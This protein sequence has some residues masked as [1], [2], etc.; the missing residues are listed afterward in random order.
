MVCI[1]KG[2]NNPVNDQ[3]SCFCFTNETIRN[4]A[5]TRCTYRKSIRD[6]KPIAPPA[7]TPV[8]SGYV[9]DN[10]EQGKW[11]RRMDAEAASIRLNK[12][13][14][15]DDNKKLAINVTPGTTVTVTQ[16][17]Y[18]SQISYSQPQM[19]YVSQPAQVIY[20]PAQVAYTPAQV[21]YSSGMRYLPSGLAFGGSNASQSYAPQ[22]LYQGAVPSL[23][24][25]MPHA[26]ASVYADTMGGWRQ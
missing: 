21:A 19:T 22:L 20:T 24:A 25:I 11:M 4:P 6:G 1:C 16:P 5:C 8:A 7:R 18:A 14:G 9:Q 13:S 15:N 10:S 23:S 3:V 17:A 26:Y 2:C 12:A